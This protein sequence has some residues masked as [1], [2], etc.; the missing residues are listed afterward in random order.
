MEQLD[1]DGIRDK[2]VKIIPDESFVGMLME[3][4]TDYELIKSSQIGLQQHI[5]FSWIVEG[6]RFERAED[7]VPKR[8]E[9]YDRINNWIYALDK[10]RVGAFIDALF[11]LIEVTE[12]RTL[13]DL[14]ELSGELP[15]K[16]HDLV[17]EYAQ[18]NEETKHTFWEI[19][20][21]MVEVIVADQQERVSRWKA[22]DKI[23]QR[24]ER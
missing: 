2:I 7:Q 15:K 17:Q 9:L 22:I 11:R 14:K 8:K 12:A 6:D 23:R 10:E 19:S 24:L 1:Y 5:C 21:F 18:I 20:L 4:K 13:T 3:S 16:M